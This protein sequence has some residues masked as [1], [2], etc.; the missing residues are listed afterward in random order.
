MYNQFVAK[1]LLLKLIKVRA[2]K[3]DLLVELVKRNL[4]GL[5]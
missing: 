5:Y 3:F 4:I 2:V 1:E